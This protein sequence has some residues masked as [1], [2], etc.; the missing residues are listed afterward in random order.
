MMM[1][2]G[3]VEGDL[4]D[5]A[6]EELE[7]ERGRLLRTSSQPTAGDASLDSVGEWLMLAYRM[8]AER[9]FFVGDDPV[10]LFTRLPASAGEADIL[11]AYRRAWSLARPRCLFLSTE[12]ELRVYALN[13]P[14]ARSV[15]E[16]DILKP[17]EIVS[18]MADV[19]EALARYH[20]ERVESG[21]FFDEKPYDSRDGRADRQLLQDVRAANDAL[22]EEGL[23]SAIAHALI[24]RVILVRYL[25][26]RS[27][28]NR[29]YFAAVERNERSWTGLLDAEPDTP[30]LGA[31]STLVSCLANR[32]L[33]YAV[34]KRLEA[35]FN[36][37][38]F[39][40]EDEEREVVHQG[41]LNLLSTLLTGQGRDHQRPLFLWA[42]DFA[43]VPTSLISSMYEQF[44]R[45]GKSDNTG[46]YYT[47][48]ELVEFV[49]GRVLTEEVLEKS[50]RI[51]DP[52]CGSGIFLVEAFRRIVGHASSAKGRSL[53]SDELRELLLSRFV[54]VDVNPEAI[55]LAAFS[56]YLAY[57]NYQEPREILRAGSLPHL[58]HRP[59]GAAAGTVLFAADAF[60]PTSDELKGQNAV[61]LPWAS[62]AF[63]VLVGNPPWTEPS[64]S[65]T[66]LGDE[67]V[68][69]NQHPVGDRSPSQNFL[70]R[71]LSFLR[72][73]GVAGLLVGATALLNSRST[74]RR[75]RSHW[76]Q[77]VELREV[78]DFTSSRA[79]FFESATAPF[80]L[81]VFQSREG[82]L[83]SSGSGMLSYS[84]VRPSL[85]LKATR[86]IA[87]A[88]L[89]RRWV[90]QKALANRDY[91]WKTYAWGNHHDEALMA[92]L[93]TEERL[94]NFLPNEPRPGFGYQR[95]KARPSKQ[96]RSLPSLKEFNYWGLL[97][98]ES[99]ED[100]PIGAK[101]QPD[102][103]LY[104]D[105]R[106]VIKVG[107]R[108]GFGPVAR[109]ETRPF[110]FR[111]T[112]YCLPLHSVPVWQARTILGT[113]LSALG[114]YRLFMANGS[115]GVWYDQFRGED[116]LGLP[117][118]MAGAQASV[119]KRISR[120]V[121][122]LYE[123]D[124]TSESGSLLSRGGGNR[125]TIL[126][127]ILLDLDEAVFDLFDATEA[128]RD[129]VRDFMEHTLPLVG[130]R[131]RWYKQPTVE[132]GERRRGTASDL[133][134]SNRSSQLDKYLSVFL[135][136]WNR[137]L[138]PRGEF[139]WFVV[140]SP[141]APMVAVVF[142][143]QNYDAP[144]VRVSETDEKSWQSAV[145]RLS[146]ALTRPVTMSIRADGTLRSVSDRSI[147]IAK[148]NEARLWT[149]SA[150]R[151]DAEA[152]ILQAMNLQAVQ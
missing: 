95:G 41:H 82:D 133:A 63:D 76:L 87:H 25:E 11:T 148:R 62:G 30:Q 37:D 94:E 5:R 136:R 121:D 8:G 4:L 102:E 149:A 58:I 101:R 150:A 131:T 115:W 23:P 3:G 111:H 141:R 19:A 29:E 7:F 128:E 59:D 65:H 27:I 119:T 118:R 93:D 147:V 145:E 48:P 124:D 10:I 85:S 68:R 66:E 75:F 138:A 116:I 40:V 146:Q 45:A 53:H 80:M 109:L 107:V 73:G 84:R 100:P 120:A 144:T 6:Y 32:D 67:W 24:E 44:Y 104:N 13:A 72:P 96:L 22:V 38:L 81:L 91:L 78:I 31:S 9:V 108:S 26:D 61:C 33:T 112:V 99:F 123:L 143:T 18:R 54:G 139:S 74:S 132:I 130:R 17:V 152:S 60:T 12:H 15:H 69:K 105:Q 51:C 79:L 135:Q 71:S 56:L 110:S 98:P 55:R 151:E 129:L 39:R 70:W 43:V 122:R 97:S 92:R 77:K 106:I 88:H 50:P 137:E 52:A 20:R 89:E 113:L 142:E 1:A 117:I 36:G 86:A 49:L 57:L 46:T 126:K 64:G 90:N 28:V 2:P 21:T 14:P 114:R 134:S 125:A 47:P 34:F 140:E 35:D 103:R 16:T 127:R 42:Y 83:S